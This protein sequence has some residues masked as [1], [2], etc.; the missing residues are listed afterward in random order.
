LVSTLFPL[1][2]EQGVLVAAAELADGSLVCAG[3]GPTLYE[4]AR[5]ELRHYFGAGLVAEL[6]GAAC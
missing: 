3:E 6:D 1:T 2:F 4:G 5:D